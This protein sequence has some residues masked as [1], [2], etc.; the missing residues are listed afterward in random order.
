MSVGHLFRHFLN[1]SNLL[2]LVLNCSRLFLIVLNC[3]E[4]VSLFFR[5][6]VNVQW[7][8]CWLRCLCQRPMPSGRLRLFPWQQE[9][10]WTWS[11]PSIPPTTCPPAN[12]KPAA[13]T[14]T[15]RASL[16]VKALPR[17]LITY[18]SPVWVIDC[19]FKLR[20]GDLNSMAH[21][22]LL[23]CS[24]LRPCLHRTHRPIPDYLAFTWATGLTNQ[25]LSGCNVP[26]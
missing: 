26:E 4:N 2:W 7:R 8:T 18:L 24:Q 13:R 16:P 17:Y 25:Q 6:G 22:S 12:A 19:L 10:G 21:L 23:F 20:P 14:S 11:G 1:C 5:S 15:G 9:E 3:N